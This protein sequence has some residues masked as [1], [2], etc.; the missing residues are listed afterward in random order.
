MTGSADFKVALNGGHAYL[1][2]DHLHLSGKLFDM[3][4]VVILNMHTPLSNGFEFLAMFKANCNFPKEQIRVLVL[5]DKLSQ[6]ELELLKSYNVELVSLNTLSSAIRTSY[7]PAPEPDK[8]EVYQPVM[9]P[10]IRKR[11]FT[12]GHARA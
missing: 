8:E 12:P 1:H 4:L 6:Q 5:E 10:Q 2:I 11:G 9:E 7:S 3:E